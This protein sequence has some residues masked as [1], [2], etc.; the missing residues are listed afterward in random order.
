MKFIEFHII[1]CFLS[2]SWENIFA[3]QQTSQQ[4]LKEVLLLVFSWETK[5]AFDMW[6]G[7]V[8]N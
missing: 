6:G 7:A 8:G 1:F 3:C 4:T 5:L 2:N